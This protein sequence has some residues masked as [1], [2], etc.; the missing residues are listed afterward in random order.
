LQQLIQQNDHQARNHQLHDQE[1]ADAGAQVARLAVQTG[2]DEDAGLAE[3]QNNGEQL[4]RRLV[5]LAVRLEVEVDVDEVSA[6]EE[7]VAVSLT[8]RRPL[9]ASTTLTWKTMP[10]EMMGVVPSSIKV[11][12]L[13]ASIIRSQ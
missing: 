6:G 3:R 11:P 8:F 7:L 5:Q 13:L 9:D 4:L 10:E 12:R 2:E 1:Q